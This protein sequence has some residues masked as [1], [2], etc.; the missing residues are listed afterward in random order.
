MSSDA[1]QELRE[2]LKDI[3]Q[4]I[5]AHTAI[6]KFQKAEAAARDAG[7]ELAKI[8]NIIQA[9]VN[10]PGKGKPKE[11]DAINRAAFILLTA[12]FQGF[13]EDLHTELGHILLNGKVSDAAAVIK[14][15]RPPRSNPHVD[16]I[17][18]MFSGIGV[19]ELMD[20]INW[21]K[22]SNKSVKDRLRDY[23]EIRNKIAH[24]SREKITKQKVIQLKKFVEILAEKLDE[25]VV[26]KA[27]S[28]L[29]QNPW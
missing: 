29:G 21:Q 11:V 19:Y 14:L 27:A 10:D 17:N 8:T 15:V 13:V 20:C 16:V 2:R 7:G 24:G 4:L 9:L 18:K 23:L 22:C 28:I 12:H 5:S 3:D 25:Q 1:L 6:T 26:S